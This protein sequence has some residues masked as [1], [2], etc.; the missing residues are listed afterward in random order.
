MLLEMFYFLHLLLFTVALLHG[1]RSRDSSSSRSRCYAVACLAVKRRARLGTRLRAPPPRLHLSLSHRL[2]PASCCCRCA[3][4][5]TE[6]STASRFAGAALRVRLQ[7]RRAPF[8]PRGSSVPAPSARHGPW[9]IG[10]L[11]PFLSVEGGA[12][13][14][15]LPA[16]ACGVLHCWLCCHIIV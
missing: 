7:P 10:W 15:R 13:R 14:T 2:H 4:R 11:R 16:V 6:A 1:S 8:L 9:L 3:R 5:A 12:T